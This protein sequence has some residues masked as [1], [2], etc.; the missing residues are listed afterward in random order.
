MIQYFPKPC[1]SCRNMKIKVALSNYATKS[2]V[3]KQQALIYNCFVDTSLLNGCGIK[4]NFIQTV[5]KYDLFCARE[6]YYF[7]K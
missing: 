3:K 7:Q 4:N 5:M 2:N 6:V 1:S